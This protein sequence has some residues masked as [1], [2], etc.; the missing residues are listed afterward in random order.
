MNWQERWD[1]SDK[2]RWTYTL[3]RDVSTTRCI[4]DFFMN[5]LMTGHGVFPSYQ[6]RFFGKDMICNCGNGIG[7]VK[8]IV[9]YCMKYDTVREQFFP[10]N[11][12]C[13]NV[14]E[15]IKHVQA[16]KGL[17]CIICTLFSYFV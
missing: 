7:D 3:I 10:S 8:H 13:M 2:G 12:L 14:Y 16:R 15:L 17:Y 5:Q 4:G 9:Y 11:Y 6:A 1:S